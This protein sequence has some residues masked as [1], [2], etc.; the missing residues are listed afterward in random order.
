MPVFAIY[1]NV[2]GWPPLSE[3]QILEGG[4][5]LDMAQTLVSHR[6]WLNPCLSTFS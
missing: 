4:T 3:F 1:L 6:P 5:N 2:C